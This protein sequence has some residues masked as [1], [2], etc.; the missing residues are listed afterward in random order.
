MFVRDVKSKQH[1]QLYYLIINLVTIICWDSTG[2]FST[3][4]F[5]IYLPIART[6]T[7]VPSPTPPSKNKNVF[8]P[9]IECL[10]RK[11]LK[12]REGRNFLLSTS[13]K[14]LRIYSKGGCGL[15][16]SYIVTGEVSISKNTR[17]S[18]CLL[19]F[20]NFIWRS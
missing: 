19:Y 10:F 5:I 16:K 3:E 18:D 13:S 12:I 11:N 6:G 8:S 4:K 17:I 9:K 15:R 14:E 20:Q 2:I 7:F 1:Q